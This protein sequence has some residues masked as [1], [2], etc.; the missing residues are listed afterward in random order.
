MANSVAAFL[1]CGLFVLL[2]LRPAGAT[3]VVTSYG[4]KPDGVSDS[5]QA[6]LKAWKEACNSAGPSTVYVPAGKFLLPPVELSGPCRSRSITLRIDGTLVASADY[7]R[8]GETGYWLLFD[9]VEGVTV[10]GGTLD[11][12]GAALWACKAAAGNCPDG[13][14]SLYFNNAKDVAVKG[15]TSINSELFHIV[16]LGCMG[17]NVERVTI[18]AAGN[19]PNTDGIHVERSSRVSITNTT[20]KT[21]DDCISIGPGAQNLWIE[22]VACGPGH[23][24]SIG[25][26]GKEAS[27]DG[28]Q[29]VT[30]KNT[31]FRG[32]QNG[33]RI[34]TWARKSTGFVRR[35]VFETATMQNVNNPIIIDQNYCPHNKGCPN[36]KSGVSILGVK[37]SNIKGS[38]ATPVAVTFSC[39]P[40][41]PCKA[42]EMEDVNLMYQ[43]QPAKSSCQNVVGT[44]SGL[45][46]PPSCF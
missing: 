1:V 23:G 9:S 7:R 38:S 6:F 41:A 44:A 19:S 18:S 24:I 26:L 8:H 11:G 39:S 45:L 25:S 13:A 40:A 31:L 34:K 46:V 33:L 42:I 14:T 35:V 37:Y 10:E 4:A 15:L 12:R 28:V 43:Q 32:S 2:F 5:S 21:G 29:N 30:V 16:F 20:I 36:Q 22:Q 17:V 27:E 3:Y